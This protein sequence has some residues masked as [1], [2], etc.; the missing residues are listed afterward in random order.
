METKEYNITRSFSRKLN[1]GAYGGQRFENIDL[2]AAHGDTLPSGASE[3]DARKLSEELHR[4]C[5]AEVNTTVQEI[6][7]KL[8]E[9]KL[10]VQQEE[11]TKKSGKTPF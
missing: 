10:K 5:V 7:K 8:Q 6:V 1:L 4:R 2:F 9:D 3:E 11:V